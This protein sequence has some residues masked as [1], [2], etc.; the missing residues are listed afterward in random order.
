MPPE[1]VSEPRRVQ[2]DEDRE[3]K[4]KKTATAILPTRRVKWAPTCASLDALIY[5]FAPGLFIAIILCVFFMD[6]CDRAWT[7]G[8]GRRV[9]GAS[10]WP[11]RR[12]AH[13]ASRRA[14]REGAGRV[15][16]RRRGAPRYAG[17]RRIKILTNLGRRNSAPNYVRQ[18]QR[19]RFQQSHRAWV[20]P[21]GPPA[22]PTRPAT[23]GHAAAPRRDAETP[24][25]AD[26][27]QRVLGGSALT[28]PC[29]FRRIIP[30]IKFRGGP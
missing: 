3:A 23:G 14:G 27:M 24:R 21:W 12:A 2:F 7:G 11:C 4:K 22:R 1:Q 13:G 30:S 28:A 5:F 25:Q 6:A 19:R 9:V 29:S 8:A 17:G 16:R 10:V 18:A 20:G 26:V 15:S